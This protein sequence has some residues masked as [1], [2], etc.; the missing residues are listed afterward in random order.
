MFA[1]SGGFDVMLGNPP[2]ERIKLSEKE[3]FATRDRAIA[4]APNK[5]A[6]ERLI[7]RALSPRTRR[8]KNALLA[9]NGSA[10][11]T[12]RVRRDLLRES[13][14]YPLTATGDIN[15]YAIFV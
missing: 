10:Q 3:F 4:G 9:T 14:R 6:R 7:K 2:W 12:A 11:S 1:R 13:G 5:A 8:L 15:T